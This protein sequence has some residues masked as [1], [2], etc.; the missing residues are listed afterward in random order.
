MTEVGDIFVCDN[1]NLYGYIS[2]AFSL[3]LHE[4][5]LLCALD[6]LHSRHFMFLFQFSS[7]SNMR[8]NL[9]MLLYCRFL[10]NEC[11]HRMYQRRAL[12]QTDILVKL[13]CIN[14]VM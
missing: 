9:R 7:E 1:L 6:I 4:S 3:V 13:S 12:N 11:N 2:R 5:L 10:W 14:F 8:P